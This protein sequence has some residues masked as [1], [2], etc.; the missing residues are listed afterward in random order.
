MKTMHTRKIISQI[1]VSLDGFI[2]GNRQELDWHVVDDEYHEYAAGILDSVDTILFGRVTY[3]HMVGFWPTPFARENFPSIADKMNNLPKLVFSRTGNNVDW[4]GTKLIQGDAAEHLLS[5]KQ[6]PGKDMV[7]LGSSDLASSLTEQR[8]I[9]EY[10]IIV[11]PVILGAG[12]PYFKGIQERVQ[13]TLHQ[14]KPF[15]SGNVLL[16]YRPA[17]S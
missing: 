13:L 5:L 7:I 14:V 17:D 11:N 1:M 16:C 4:T 8:V 9:D 15:Q 10:H 2:E 6:K 12:K 3:E